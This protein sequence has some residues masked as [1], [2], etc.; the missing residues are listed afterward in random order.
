LIFEFALGWILR[1]GETFVEL[2]SRRIGMFGPC[3][4]TLTIQPRPRDQL[5]DNNRAVVA[6]R[7]IWPKRLTFAIAKAR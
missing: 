2:Q 4:A 5:I 3:G 1:H 6:H 7:E